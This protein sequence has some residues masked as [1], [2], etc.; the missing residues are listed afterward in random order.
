MVTW[1][2]SKKDKRLSRK[3]LWE[4]ISNQSETITQMADSFQEYLI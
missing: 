3:E 1:K 4:I 2:L